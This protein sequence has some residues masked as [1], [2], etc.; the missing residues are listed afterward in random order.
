M[1]S[2]EYYKQTPVMKRILEYTDQAVYLLGATPQHS[3]SQI[4]RYPD[5]MQ[6]MGEGSDIYRSLI[7]FSG[8]NFYVDMEYANNEFPGEIF[9]NPVIAFGKL[10][11][12]RNATKEFL[13]NQGIKHVELMTGQGYNFVSRI[14]R[15]SSS[16]D[17]LVKIGKEL[18]VLPW[19]AVTKLIDKEKRYGNVPL[20]TDSL[21]FG[22][23][24]RIT[25]YMF[26]EIKKA[27]LDLKLQTS[28]L[29]DNK[30]IA[31]LDTSQYGYLIHKRS[32]RIAFSLH[33]KSKMKPQL[34]YRGPAIVTITPKGLDLDSRISIRSDERENYKAAVNLAK[35]TDTK[36]PYVDISNLITSYLLSD[37]FKTHKKESKDLPKH[38]LSDDERGMLSYL[39]P[40][41]SKENLFWECPKD[42]DWNLINSLPISHH[43]R[44]TIN[45]PNELMLKP[46]DIRH[47]VLELKHHDVT[48]NQIISLIAQKYSENHGWSSD[49]MKNDPAVR[50][51]YWVRTL[52]RQG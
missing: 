20:V 27:P 19:S 28:D 14:K 41:L 31:I 45:E 13:E 46:W 23:L 30:E 1:E 37:I 6:A 32:H 3:S 43:A 21:A 42:P 16:Y 5:I 9:H 44:K 17:A 33:Q 12:A 47:L 51:E 39:Y 10:E 8:I 11:S 18:N 24:G 15:T 34:Q 29:F 38:K 40:S 52:K 35:D 49:L 48:D 4:R 26:H 2:I 36:I 22:A 50:A 25:E 7:D